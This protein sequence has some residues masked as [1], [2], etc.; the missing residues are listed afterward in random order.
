MSQ[1]P[2]FVAISHAWS[3][4]LF[5]PGV[6]FDLQR[7]SKAVERLLTNGLPLVEHCWIDSVCIDQEDEEDKQRQIPLTAEIY[8][9]A[10]VVAVTLATY[11]NLSQEQ[12][13]ELSGSVDGVLQMYRDESW[14]SEGRR[15]VVGR[16]RKRLRE[17]MD[18]LTTFTQTPW[19][20]RVWTL[21]E[22]ILS[23]AQIWIGSDLVPTR[24]KEDLFLALPDVCE[25]LTISEC[26]GG[27]YADLYHY[28]R[29]MV[30]C[31]MG[32]TD[33]TRVM[34]V[35]GNRTASVPVDEIFGTMAASGV[36]IVVTKLSDQE[37]AR[38]LWCE[39]AIREGH[40][41]WALLPPV[42]PP[43]NSPLS[44]RDIS[45]AY[46]PFAVRHLASSSSSLDKITPLG[47]V[48][49]EDSTVSLDGQ[50]AGICT[51]ERKLGLVH[52]HPAGTIHR[53]I[54]LIFFARN[55]FQLAR[56]LAAAF[57][58]GRY[59]HKRLLII[60]QVLKHNYWRARKAILLHT[61]DSFGP[62]FRNR[63]YLFIWSDF[64]NLQST[65]MMPI[66]DGVAYLARIRNSLTGM[67]TIVVTNQDLPSK[68]YIA[69]NFGAINTSD[70]TLFTLLD[71]PT[72]KEEPDYLGSF[73][74]VGV[75]LGM[76]VSDLETAK[77]YS[78]YAMDNTSLYSSSLGGPACDGCQKESVLGHVARSIPLQSLPAM[79]R[80]DEELTPNKING[81]L[82]KIRQQEKAL[83]YS[84]RRRV[85]P[86]TK[87]N[88][89]HTQLRF[90]IRKR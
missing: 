81:I 43:S 83:S 60:A 16:R 15:W 25:S 35:L 61:E 20:T 59:T 44:H 27:K 50:F 11:L 67:T 88:T 18:L 41:R 2:P 79:A 8:G 45:C 58:G 55:D 29:G 90:R 47:R 65:H 7:G 51:V 1:L 53:D 34:E 32:V 84:P 24:I 30:G 63:Y 42:I 74:K 22:F 33:R 13:D 49:V 64:M 3:D 46:P 38:A 70:R 23:K 82:S 12:V 9:S 62:R 6:S 87:R 66:N 76:Q 37:K 89:S 5:R 86:R 73:H 80:R 39:Q 31:S 85:L 40:L 71:F 19:A 77:I 78:G 17:A 72:L 69:V 26:I 56:R 48:R 54:T 21:Q 68:E 36:M 4:A 28:Y 10:E 52:Q 57:G 75:T 14:G